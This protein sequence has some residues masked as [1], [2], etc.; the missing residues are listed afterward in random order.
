MKIPEPP[1][2]LELKRVNLSVTQ[3]MSVKYVI[4]THTRVRLALSSASFSLV[5]KELL[6]HI[7]IYMNTKK[8]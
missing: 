1:R 7:F 4:C 6:T 8:M 5:S 2:G 3:F